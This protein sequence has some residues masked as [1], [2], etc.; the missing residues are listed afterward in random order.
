MNGLWMGIENRLTQEVP[1][2]TGR[3]YELG[4][5]QAIENRRD[6]RSWEDDE[7]F[8][9]LVL[10]LLSGQTEWS[11]IESN[12][13][14][15]DCIF[16]GF[17]IKKFA[18]STPSDIRDR[19]VPSI[20]K[21]K[22]GSPNQE[23]QLMQLIETAKKLH[24]HSRLNGSV[25]SYFTQ[26]FV[27]CDKDTKKVALELG[28]Y[29]GNHKL[30]GFGVPLAAEALKNLGFD[31]AKADRH[32]ARAAACFGLVEFGDAWKGEEDGYGT[33]ASRNNKI[34]Q[35]EVMKALE[36]IGRFTGNYCAFIDNAIWL[37]CAGT[38]SG[39]AHLNNLELRK[40]AKAS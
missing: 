10:A 14:E 26:L 37:L 8:K 2:W 22:A 39:G 16:G 20:Q 15:L 21:L 9:G 35:L 34:N 25:E 6:G 1:N 5:I 28:K 33:P 7:I 17:N 18:Q 31:V 27:A 40:L 38:R 4:Q 30:P 12:L 13:W 3:V 32:V 36:D 19:I 24:T 11:R 29:R 23:R